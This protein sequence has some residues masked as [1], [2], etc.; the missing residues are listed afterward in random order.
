M[1]IRLAIAILIGAFLGTHPSFADDDHAEKKSEASEH[2]D[3][4]EHEHGEEEE[5]AENV[6]PDKGIVEANESKGFK[7]S[8]EA[9]KNFE[10]K[11][12][13]FTGDGPWT[14]PSGA[15]VHS[16]EDTNLIRV[17]AGFFK[18]VDFKII[19]KSGTSIVVDSD[20][21]REGD[22]IAVTALGFLKI[23]ELAAFGGVAHGHSH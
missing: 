8:P 4:A 23:A 5:G 1:I 12:L 18:S 20:D 16:G 2:H 7:L 13:K 3:E 9:L 15:V 22:E 6:G 11:T 21:L 14:V 17:R 10:I 19:K